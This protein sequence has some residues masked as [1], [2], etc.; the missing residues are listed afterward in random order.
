MSEQG[1]YLLAGDFFLAVQGLAMMR[2]CVVNPELAR[3]R[4]DEIRH[5]LAHF[6]DFPHSLRLA[7][8]EYNVAE[9]YA[10]WA[11]RYDGPTWRSKRRSQ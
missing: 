4:S 10:R 2:T 11:P 7:V 5:I 3:A 6:D 9:G 8:Q 1:A